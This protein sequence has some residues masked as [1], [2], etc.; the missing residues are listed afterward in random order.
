MKEE[1]LIL[2]P[3][4]PQKTTA[5]HFLEMLSEDAEDAFL[6]DG[7]R[8]RLPGAVVSSKASVE[9]IT[10]TLASEKGKLR[11]EGGDGWWSRPIK[12][13][14]LTNGGSKTHGGRQWLHSF[15][16][17]L[18]ELEGLVEGRSQSTMDLAGQLALREAWWRAPIELGRVLTAS[19]FVLWEVPSPS[20]FEHDKPGSVQRAL[21]DSRIASHQTS[22]RLLDAVDRERK[23]SA[24]ACPRPKPP[25]PKHGVVVV[26]A[27]TRAPPVTMLDGTRR[28][29]LRLSRRAPASRRPVMMFVLSWEARRRTG[30]SI[31]RTRSC[32]V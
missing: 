2:R 17:A 8:F 5:R 4:A 31:G 23:V 3:L 32:S 24:K 12:M 16:A 9:A 10:T 22:Q 19:S 21:R 18:D 29:A 26:T 7:D 6:I 1:G 13:V 30:R 15:R 14:A 28:S 27:R 20:K 11:F 25:A